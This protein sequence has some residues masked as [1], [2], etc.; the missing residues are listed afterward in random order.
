MVIDSN[1]Y[2]GRSSHIIA[3]ENHR[4][5]FPP[6]YSYCKHWMLLS[7][8]ICLT[9]NNSYVEEV[10]N[11]AGISPLTALTLI[12]LHALTLTLMVGR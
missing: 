8:G 12:W 10:M 4:S 5:C 3:T 9:N 6:H 2:E 7:S 11:R 1:N